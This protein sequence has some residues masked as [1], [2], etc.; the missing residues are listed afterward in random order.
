[1]SSANPQQKAAVGLIGL[2]VMGEN[3]A[4]NI[5]RNEF[6]IAVF[7]RDT[8]KV[9][10]FLAR[11][12]EHTKGRNV[13]GTYSLEEFVSALVARVLDRCA[14]ELKVLER[15]TAPLERVVPPF[16]RITYTEAIERLRAAG[17]PIEWGDDFGADE[18]T[19]ISEAFDRPVMEERLSDP[20]A[21]PR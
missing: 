5:A 10:R 3:L 9:D 12:E 7:N 20:R 1:M 6:P 19:L 18:E 17:N 13:I 21:E 8:T 15:D 4:L 11:A 2:A 16:P 14:E